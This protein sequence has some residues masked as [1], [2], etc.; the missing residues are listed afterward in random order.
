MDSKVNNEA[1]RNNSSTYN[2]NH[3]NICSTDRECI[4]YALQAVNALF[5]CVNSFLGAPYKSEL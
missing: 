4:L 3:T 5:Y 2:K 1:D